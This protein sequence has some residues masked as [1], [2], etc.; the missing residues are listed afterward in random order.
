MIA[1]V[2]TQLSLSIIKDARHFIF[3]YLIRFDVRFFSRYPYLF[4]IINQ[5]KSHHCVIKMCECKCGSVQRHSSD[6]QELINLFESLWCSAYP[7]YFAVGRPTFYAS[8]YH[9][10]NT[11]T[12]TQINTGRQKHI[13]LLT[14]KFKCM[15][16]NYINKCI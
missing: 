1:S 10:N 3:I 14:R 15:N 11:L 12:Q 8:A 16:T 2:Q 9:I 13:Y 6:K 5:M 7:S 4:T